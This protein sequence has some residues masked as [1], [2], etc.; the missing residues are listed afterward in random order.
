MIS[1]KQKQINDIILFYKKNWNKDPML[2]KITYADWLHN[3]ITRWMNDDESPT[4]KYRNYASIVLKVNTQDE[5]RE[6]ECRYDTLRL[7]KMYLNAF[8]RDD[9]DECILFLRERI[10]EYL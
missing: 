8:D 7:C 10:T 9:L 4:I 3:D 2:N 5:I 1:S 6:R